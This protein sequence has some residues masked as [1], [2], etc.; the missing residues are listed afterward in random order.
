[1]TANVQLNAPDDYKSRPEL[2]ADNVK[3]AAIVNNAVV[4]LRVVGDAIAVLRGKWWWRFVPKVVRVQ[5]DSAA[6]EVGERLDESGIVEASE[7]GEVE[8]KAASK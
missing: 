8:V 1:M 3:L 6:K 2:I 7:D 5:V 4:V